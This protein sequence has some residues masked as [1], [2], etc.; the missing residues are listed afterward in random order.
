[1]LFFSRGGAGYPRPLSGSAN[2]L[3]AYCVKIPYG[4]V[5]ASPD[6]K[7]R[8]KLRSLTICGVSFS[9]SVFVFLRQRLSEA[10]CIQYK[11]TTRYVLPIKK[12]KSRSLNLNLKLSFSLSVLVEALMCI[13]DEQSEIIFRSTKTRRVIRTK[14]TE[15]FSKHLPL[16]VQL[17]KSRLIE[18]S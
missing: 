3:T 9:L 18:I 16:F 14:K 4:E 15:L 2:V 5:V 17:W 10:K 12:D 8:S 7:R 13:T 11:N 6:W 1:M